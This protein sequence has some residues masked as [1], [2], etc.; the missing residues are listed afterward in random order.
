MDKE[1]EKKRSP[2][3]SRGQ[4]AKPSREGGTTSAPALDRQSTYVREGSDHLNTAEFNA[5]VA[6]KAYELF[7]RR[8]HETGNDVQDWLTAEQLVKDEIARANS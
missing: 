1:M 7:E 8:G 2:A 4:K 5:R 6:R 3:Q